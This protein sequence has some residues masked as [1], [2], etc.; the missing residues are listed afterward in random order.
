VAGQVVNGSTVFSCEFMLVK[1][2]GLPLIR[3]PD[4]AT[5][6]NLWAG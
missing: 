3:Q 4:E 1:L 5:G 2:E 6:L